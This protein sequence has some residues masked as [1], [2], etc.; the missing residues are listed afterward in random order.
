MIGTNGYDSRFFFFFLFLKDM[1]GDR[2]QPLASKI[3]NQSN[4]SN[5]RILHRDSVVVL[6]QAQML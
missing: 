6:M 1:H 5:D 3:G 2:F 4:V